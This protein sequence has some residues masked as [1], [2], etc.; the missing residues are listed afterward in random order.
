[1][2]KSNLM[3]MNMILKFE[4][5]KIAFSDH[6]CFAGR[7]GDCA[8][9][10]GAEEVQPWWKTC[11]QEWLQSSVIKKLKLTH[12]KTHS[13]EKANKKYSHGGKPA[14]RGGCKVL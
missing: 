2:R 1:M 3:F 13:G 9:A 7:T 6:L 11:K 12:L 4:E 8:E 5:E 10:D 14:N